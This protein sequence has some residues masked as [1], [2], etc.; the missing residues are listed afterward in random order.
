ML[1]IHALI[2]PNFAAARTRAKVARAQADLQAVAV[3]L[4]SYRVDQP[5]YPYNID[6]LFYDS[7]KVIWRITT[8]VAYLSSL[9]LDPFGP[10]RASSPYKYINERDPAS[11]KGYGYYGPDWVQWVKETYGPNSGTKWVYDK[12]RDYQWYLYSIGPIGTN[13]P[14]WYVTYDPSNGTN[15]LGTIQRGG[16]GGPAMRHGNSG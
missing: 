13:N 8:P 6:G 3:G 12:M 10:W 4:D 5:A 11:V 16:P 14:N 2:I 9:P 7:R 15:S 1:L